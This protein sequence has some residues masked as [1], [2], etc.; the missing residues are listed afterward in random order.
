MKT[1]V[2]SIW[3]ELKVYKHTENKDSWR[4][5]KVLKTHTENKDIWS[6][7]KVLTNTQRKNKYTAGHQEQSLHRVVSAVLGLKGF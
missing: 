7:L 4:E 5:L 2:L 1:C 3:R 6:E